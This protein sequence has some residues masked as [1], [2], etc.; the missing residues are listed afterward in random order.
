MLWGSISILP[1]TAWALSSSASLGNPA[2][3]GSSIWVRC[4]SVSFAASAGVA[5]PQSNKSV[6]QAVY[7]RRSK[8][9][10]PRG[11]WNRTNNTC[12]VDRGMSAPVE[13][14]AENGFEDQVVGRRGG[15]D[16]DADVDLPKGRHVKVGDDE[17]LLLLGVH[18]RNIADCAVVGVPLDAAAHDTAKIV[19][20]FGARRE[21]QALIDIRT[22]PGAFERG[23]EREIPAPDALVD[24]RADL[25]GPRISRVRGTLEADFGREA[26]P[27]RPSPGVRYPNARANMIAHP[28][29]AM[30]VLLA[31]KDIEPDFRPVVETLREFDRLV[32]LMIRWKDAVDGLLLTLHGEIRVKFDHQGLRRDGLRPVDLDLVVGL[33]SR[34]KRQERER[35][36]GGEPPESRNSL[37]HSRTAS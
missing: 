36:E 4:L 3:L 17:E 33:G 13:T 31:G 20:D 27:H 30:A 14:A 15:A 22:M 28:L 21:A 1:M 23:V 29:H 12:S 16:P 34:K 10:K 37:R 11:L 8:R 25:P 9:A 26:H 18:R 7:R 5:W 35:E 2:G 32:F 24:D 19:A 6:P